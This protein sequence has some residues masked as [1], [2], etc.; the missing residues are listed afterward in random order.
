MKAISIRQPYAHCVV[1]GEK[2]VENRTRPTQHRGLL[3][4]H[5]AK[6]MTVTDCD[7]VD[8]LAK[9]A[10]PHEDLERG[11][12]IGV[13]ELVDV[14]EAHRS[15]WFSGPF[16]YVLRNARRLPFIPCLGQVGLWNC[17]P[18]VLSQLR[19]HV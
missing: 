10:L 12:I 19:R 9:T 2:P 6:V 15:R 5:A 8:D 7:R 13:V 1:T 14:V 4:I 16:G 17:P 3:L 11:G 18:E